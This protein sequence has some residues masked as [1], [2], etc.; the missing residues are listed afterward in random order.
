M[1][2]LIVDDS[3]DSRLLLE[4]I[5]HKGGL[6]DIL[7]ANSAAEAFEYLGLGKEAEQPVDIDLILMDLVMPEIDGIEALSHI[8][9]SRSLRDIPVIMVTVQEEVENLKTALENG[10]L[11]F[12]SKPVNKIELLA[13]VRSG[14]KFKHEIDRR[15][16]QEKR[17]RETNQILQQLSLLDGLTGIANRRHFDQFLDQ[18]WQRAIR[19]TAPLALIMIDI[20]YFKIYNDR[21][22]HQ[23]GDHCLQRVAQILRD[24]LLRSSDLVA[25]YG[26]EEFAIVLPDTNQAGA[27]AVAEKLRVQVAAAG[28]PHAGSKA[29]A[30]VTVSLGVGGRIPNPAYHPADLI[31][32]VDHA[33]YQAKRAGRNRVIAADENKL[34]VQ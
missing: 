23:M 24:N 27:M 15:K 16:A 6:E 20:D 34:W 3:E 12:I 4:R 14:L 9:Q 10:A 33:L 1:S 30:V 18:E 22:G 8:K 13:R 21:Y 2:I 25:R 32:A 31:A 11:D 29:G 17:L 28:I 7:L 26:G 5:L 19:R